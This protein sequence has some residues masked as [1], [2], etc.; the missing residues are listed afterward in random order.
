MPFLHMKIKLN[1][2]LRGSDAAIATVEMLSVAIYRVV[3]Q[4]HVPSIGGELQTLMEFNRSLQ[5]LRNHS[6]AVI[7]LR[8]RASANSLPKCQSSPAEYSIFIC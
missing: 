2:Y 5:R 7:F 8:K 1:Y 4:L 6:I 3:R